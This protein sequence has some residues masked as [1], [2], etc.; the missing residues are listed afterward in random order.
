MARICEY[1]NDTPT[2]LK[3]DNFLSNRATRHCINDDPNW[4]YPTCI[5]EN[6]R[7]ET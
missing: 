6:L 1:G 7:F 2:Y 4:M 5:Q 3:V